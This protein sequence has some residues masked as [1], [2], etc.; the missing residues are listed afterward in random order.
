[1]A[2]VPLLG[3]YRTQ[4]KEWPPLYCATVHVPLAGKTFVG[5]WT[6]GQREAQIDACSKIAEFLDAEFP[7][8]KGS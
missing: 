1:M 8:T 6:R 5:T 2:G 4:D 3:W 7:R